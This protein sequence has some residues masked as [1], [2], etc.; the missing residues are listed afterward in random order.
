MSNYCDASKTYDLRGIRGGNQTSIPFY[1]YPESLVELPGNGLLRVGERQQPEKPSVTLK[2]RPRVA[3]RRVAG[4]VAELVRLGA[5]VRRDERVR[6]VVRVQEGQQFAVGVA[7]VIV[8]AV[9]ALGE[10]VGDEDEDLAVVLASLVVVGEDEGQGV[11][12]LEAVVEDLA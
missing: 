5:L 12:H 2:L 11:G 8:G 10:V 9:R 6:G 3:L 1:S 4:E 7:V